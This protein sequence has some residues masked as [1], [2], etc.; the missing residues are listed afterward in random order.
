MLAKALDR[1]LSN[2]VVESKDFTMTKPLSK[3]KKFGHGFNANGFIYDHL[4]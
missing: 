1:A 4:P 3:K 2:K